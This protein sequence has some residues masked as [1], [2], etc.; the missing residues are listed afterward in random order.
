MD[1]PLEPEEAAVLKRLLT[2]LLD[3]VHQESAT[4]DTYHLRQQ[5]RRDAAVLQA[6]VARLEDHEQS[7][8]SEH[9]TPR[10]QQA[11]EG[12]SVT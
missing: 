8:R 11:D 9:L 10:Q 6:I 7:I 1:L 2:R 5:L 4:L 12:R 3:G